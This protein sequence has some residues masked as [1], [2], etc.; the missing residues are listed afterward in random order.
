MNSYYIKLSVDLDLGMTPCKEKVKLPL[1]FRPHD[2]R[3]IKY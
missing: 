3:C 1:F 2:C